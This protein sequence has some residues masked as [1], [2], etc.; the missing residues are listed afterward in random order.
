M[1]R[2]MKVFTSYQTGEDDGLT[3]NANT[4]RRFL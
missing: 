4:I 2:A 1:A 3:F